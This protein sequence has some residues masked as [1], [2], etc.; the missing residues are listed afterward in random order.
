VP[1]FVVPED[2]ND[3][4]ND[5]NSF[6]GISSPSYDASYVGQTIGPGG[7]GM[8]AYMDRPETQP[9]YT[10]YD[11]S[12]G[13]D[14]NTYNLGQ[15]YGPTA[16]GMSA[17]M[18][19]PGPMQM[20]AA[21]TNI[22]YDRMGPDPDAGILRMMPQGERFNPNVVMAGLPFN[23]FQ[24]PTA[25]GGI[26]DYFSRKFF[27][28]DD[29]ENDFLNTPPGLPPSDGFKPY[30][31]ND[32]NM[33]ML[34]DGMELDDMPMEDILEMMQGEKLEA[35]ADTYSL[36][37]L[38]QMIQDARDSGNEDELQLLINDLEMMYPGATT[39]I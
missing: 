39:T 21:P 10:S 16:M 20:A 28:D 19:R 38:L 12:P 37:N 30:D 36:P 17:Y 3:I 29:P 9:G 13:Y 22:G 4:I 31:P 35:S 18:D 1:L 5:P 7:M 33:F 25:D 2:D 34:P 14:T 23:L 15:T 8:S 32:P 26:I 24:D 6:S 11:Y 27:G